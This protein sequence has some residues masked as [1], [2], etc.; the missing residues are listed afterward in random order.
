M[1]VPYKTSAPV[2]T[3]KSSSKRQS[4]STHRRRCYAYR[5]IYSYGR[6][7]QVVA[8]SATVMALLAGHRQLCP[9]GPIVTL[10]Q[11]AFVGGDGPH[12]ATPPKTRPR[13]RP[14]PLSATHPREGQLRK[15]FVDCHHYRDKT[16]ITAKV[17]D[18]PSLSCLAAP[19]P[20]V[21]RGVPMAS[22]GSGSLDGRSAL[23][24]EEIG[25]APPTLAAACAAS[26]VP[27]VS[28]F[29]SKALGRKANRWRIG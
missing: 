15:P 9:W 21:A 18:E 29:P 12:R 27:I 19:V 2:S 13:R 16:C 20:T 6:A 28:A 24:G 11:A 23:A 1:E 10:D 14:S 25:V 7:S 4:T 3:R 22:G 26:T 17:S 8:Y 5:A